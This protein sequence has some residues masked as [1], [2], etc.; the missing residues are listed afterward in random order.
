VRKGQV[1]GRVQV[2][3]GRRLLGTRPLVAA[4]SISKPGFGGRVAWYAGRTL[5]HIRGLFS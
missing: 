1:L 4:R 3:E 5:H 2:W